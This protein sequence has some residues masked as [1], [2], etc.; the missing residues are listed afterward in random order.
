MNNHF[1]TIQ[2]ITDYFKNEHNTLKKL[3]SYNKISIELIFTYILQN[4]DELSQDKEDS[5][6]TTFDVLLKQP[7]TKHEYLLFCNKQDKILRNIIES[8]PT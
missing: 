2:E 7:Y 1:T 5:Y 6:V 4:L 3:I 8:L